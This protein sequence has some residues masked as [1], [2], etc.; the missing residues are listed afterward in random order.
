M[1]S[2][3]L[4]FVGRSPHEYF[5]CHLVS[6]HGSS[7]SILLLRSSCDFLVS[8]FIR[9]S[10]CVSQSYCRIGQRY[11]SLFIQYFDDT[12]CTVHRTKWASINKVSLV[13]VISHWSCVTAGENTVAGP[14]GRFG[15]RVLNDTRAIQYK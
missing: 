11:S 8:C 2:S 7:I 12:T 1:S 9:C 4:S 13:R 10:S 15:I 3:H 14:L 5:R 6:C